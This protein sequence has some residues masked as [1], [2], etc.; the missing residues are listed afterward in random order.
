MAEY[1]SIPTRCNGTPMADLGDVS[2]QQTRT[3]NQKVVQ[4]ADGLPRVKILYGA[5]KYQA[6]LTFLSLEDKQ[7]F[8][9]QVGA[10]DLKP[11]A[12]NLGFDMGQ[13]SF[14][15]LRG[16]CSGV[17]ATSNQDGDASLQVTAM[18]EELQEE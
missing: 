11:A 17:T 8:L 2:I 16:I 15:L 14:S 1:A 10:W 4:G 9:K 3:V 5:P 6:T 13:D 7:A 18:Y 12:H